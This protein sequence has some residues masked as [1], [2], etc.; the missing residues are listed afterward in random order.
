MLSQIIT[1]K[2]SNLFEIIGILIIYFAYINLKTIIGLHQNRVN[3]N[4]S[5]IIKFLNLIISFICFIS[6]R[7][8]ANIN[9]KEIKYSVKK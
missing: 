2:F 4:A 6:I 1:N 8:I 7:L 3:H 9:S 5:K